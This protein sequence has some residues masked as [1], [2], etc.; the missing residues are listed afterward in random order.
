MLKTLN[1]GCLWMKR[2]KGMKDLILQYFE[3]VFFKRLIYLFEGGDGQRER[4]N[5]KQTPY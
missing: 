4:E 3:H 1:N 5:L 2:L